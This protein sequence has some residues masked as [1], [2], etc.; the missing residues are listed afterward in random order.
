MNLLFSIFVFFVMFNLCSSRYGQP[1]RYVDYNN[2]YN[3]PPT[4]NYN[5]Y[6]SGGRQQGG[7]GQSNN[8]E[9]EY[10]IELKVDLILKM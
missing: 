4:N 8:G 10:F 1:N 7:W 9:S 6:Y 2:N 3:Q 5:N